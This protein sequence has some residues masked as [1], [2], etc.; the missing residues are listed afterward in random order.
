M[1]ALPAVPQVLRVDHGFT[2]SED[3]HAKVHMFFRYTGTPPSNADLVTVANFLKTSWS[4]AGFQHN[5]TPEKL[6]ETI[7]ITDLTS[8]TSSVGTDSASAI[9]GVSTGHVLPADVAALTSWEIARRFRGGHPRAYWPFGTSEDL[10]DDQTWNNGFLTTVVGRFNTYLGDIVTATWAGGG[11][12]QQ[13][14]VSFYEGFTVHTG[15]TG[16]ARNVSTVRLVPVV[17][18]V[19]SFILRAGLASQRKRLLRLA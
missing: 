10:A 17:D 14:S 18:N 6:L 8:S 3:T 2:L 4:A 16:R 15:T 5:M 7:T 11:I 1:P 9:D 19:V 13:V 12:H